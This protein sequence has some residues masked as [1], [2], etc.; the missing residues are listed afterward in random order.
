MKFYDTNALLLLQEKAF[1]ER[2]AI[3]DVTLRE[4]ENI[5]TSNTKSEDVKYKA[6]KLSHLLDDHF[7]EYDLYETDPFHWNTLP[8]DTLIIE[9]AEDAAKLSAIEFVTNDICCKNIARMNNL[10]V[11]SVELDDEE[12][13]TGFLNVKMTDEEMSYFYTH[14]D[15]NLYDL[16]VNQYLIIRNQEDEVVDTY[17]WNGEKY[18]PLYKK[19][20][21]SIYF[22]KLKAKDVYQSCVI[23]SIM[24]NQLTAISGKAGS[25]KSLLSLMTIM[26]LIKRGEYDRVVVMFNPTKTRGAADMGFYSGDSNRKAMSNSI[27][28]I[29][30]T[31][32]GD[33]SAVDYLLNDEKIKLVSIAD[34]RGMEIRDREILYISE[35]QNTSIDLIKLCLT[36]VSENAKVII[37]G[38]FDAQVDSRI[39]EGTNNGLKRVVQVFKGEPEFGYVELQK[40]FRSRIAQLCEKL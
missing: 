30:T 24:N 39:F 34:C 33:R 16:L 10:I 22:E 3:S 18:C 35:A 20:V 32:F 4:L 36:R 12:R 1:E 40:I 17:R 23:D 9:A 5:K 2:F 13:Y 7:G 29:L 21:E 25:G 11:G 26:N 15:E 28:N 6:R 31:K 27:G 37:E 14:M 8:P 38:D 19:S